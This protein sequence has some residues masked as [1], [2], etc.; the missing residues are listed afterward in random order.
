MKAL[1]LNSGMGSRMGSLTKKK[2]KCMTE[3]SNGETILKRQLHQLLKAGIKEVVITTGMHKDE[4]MKYC[5]SLNLSLNYTFIHNPEYK[6]TN[7]IYSI[8]LA[9]D[10]LRNTD[11]LLMHGDLVFD[12]EVLSRI[13]RQTESSVV[14]SSVRPLPDKDFKAVI[15]DG[16]VKKIGVEYFENAVS[17]QALYYL[18]A[19]DWD[20]W[21]K[22]IEVYCRCGKRNVYA[23]NALN[24]VT[25][26]CR[27]RPFDVG[28]ALCDE[29]DTPEDLRKI[30]EY[31]EKGT[32]FIFFLEGNI[33]GNMEANVQYFKETELF[34]S[35]IK[36]EKHK[37]FVVCRQSF[38]QSALRGKI[39]REDLDLVYFHDFSPN[40]T[41]ASVET[42]VNEYRKS[43]CGA[44]MA[45][46]G[47]SAIDV[48]KAVKAF[49]SMKEN[50]NYLEQEILENG[51][52]LYAV[53]TT[54]GSGSE[55][56][57][58][59]VIYY[60][61]EKQSLTHSSLLP[62]KVL[63]E[64]SVLKGL[65]LSQRKATMMDALCHAIEAFWSVQ[66]T[67]E[68][69][70]YSRDALTAVMKYGEGYL[71][72]TDTGN[73]GMMYAANMAGRAINIAKTTAAH[74]MSYQLTSRYH[75]P[76]GNAVAICLPH[77]WLYMLEHLERCDDARGAAY[78]TGIFT[79]IAGALGCQTP[80]EA[81]RLLWDWI[82]EMEL[83]IPVVSES[84]IKD[85]AACVNPDRLKNNPVKL[86][87]QD[88]RLIYR[89]LF[90]GDI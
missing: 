62:Q 63:L 3:V 61:G 54:A 70:E 10:I 31:E 56:T 82:R 8:Y 64:P 47:G 48:A 40:P 51:I 7:Y 15:N 33:I 60:R 24:E 52:P 59:A 16:Y 42:G 74:A 4:L 88:I 28:D 49:A 19:R 14:V 2:P 34:L 29:I 90:T 17:A 22:Q 27:I 73:K 87:Q 65:P 46:G 72:N 77:L 55:A 58:F 6:N 30:Q 1:I 78:L 41:Y 79:D 9:K 21:L 37:L 35:A 45:I 84:E 57:E 18:Y 5:S 11:I 71:R 38:L 32:S 67:Q 80:R 85:L 89:H 50:K 44:I 69:R 13:I 83:E 39:E 76:H 43:G 23:E 26:F 36:K 12:F 75:L 68:S 86:E 66:S 81:I 20:I 53:P 25:D